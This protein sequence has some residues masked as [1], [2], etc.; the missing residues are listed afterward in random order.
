MAVK[1]S[2]L[3]LLLSQSGH[4]CGWLYFRTLSRPIARHCAPVVSKPSI[5]TWCSSEVFAE[6]QDLFVRVPTLWVLV[7]HM[8]PRRKRP[9]LMVSELA[10]GPETAA[11]PMQSSEKPVLIEIACSLVDSVFDLRHHTTQSIHQQDIGY[12]KA[13]DGVFQWPVLHGGTFKA[14]AQRAW[15]DADRLREL[16]ATFVNKVG[17]SSSA[18]T[19]EFLQEFCKVEAWLPKNNIVLEKLFQ[20]TSPISNC[21]SNNT[22]HG[23]QKKGF[24]L[25]H[26]SCAGPLTIQRF[27]E[28]SRLRWQRSSTMQGA[29]LLPVSARFAVGQEH[30][31]VIH[32]WSVTF[33]Q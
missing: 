23:H 30:I 9:K 21:W 15:A 19:K 8:A 27:G 6:F 33:F 17:L 1:S 4:D 24:N 7:A 32:P 26:R 13:K 18:D 25:R 31:L 28:A 2:C 12:L 20:S 10:A 29:L 16:S 22:R 14:V 3:S 5:L 11:V